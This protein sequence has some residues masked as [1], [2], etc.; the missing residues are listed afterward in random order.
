MLL[1]TLPKAVLALAVMV[2][3]L[4]AQDLE[5]YDSEGFS[6]GYA[7]GSY[8]PLGS[9]Q[10][11][12]FDLQ[13]PWAHGYIQYMPFYGA[14]KHFRPYNYK[15]VGAQT[16]TA[17]GWGMSPVMPYSQQFWHRYH[18]RG[19][20]SNGA[21]NAQEA[22]MQ[23]PQPKAF[24][25]RVEK[26]KAPQDPNPLNVYPNYPPH[27]YQPEVAPVP[28]GGPSTQYQN[29]YQPQYNQ[30]PHS[31]PGM[32]APYSGVSYQNG[33]VNEYPQQQQQQQPILMAP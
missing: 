12:P 25:R 31:G 4:Q 28:Q 7:E 30:Q 6:G 2:T 24:E 5:I 22:L 10:L 8:G 19:T 15:H 16:Q 27:Q 1:R 14:Y 17:A 18:A 26:N 23:Y 13:N 3:G 32:M 20:M 33:P 11:Y 21:S 9:E 29:R